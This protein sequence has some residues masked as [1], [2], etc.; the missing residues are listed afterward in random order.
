[1]ILCDD[2]ALVRAGI[3]SVVESFRGW[4]VVAE[5]GDG[6]EALDLVRQHQPD[7][8]LLDLTLPGL[9]G[10]EV[11]QRIRKM[12][13]RTK[14]LILSMHAA[15]EYVARALYAGSTGYLIKEAAVDEL[16]AALETVLLGRRYLS[17]AVDE[18]VVDRVLEAHPSP[19]AE[20]EVLTARQREV[21]QLIAEGHSTRE[22][23]ERLFVSVKTVEAHRM[24]LME[25]LGIRDVPGLVRF[26]IRTGVITPDS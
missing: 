12:D 18:E 25:R 23:A 4:E 16:A 21:L 7:V 6:I 20:L 2:H 14:V 17:R 19:A 9:N 24:Q 1:M 15:P 13:I 10:F 22:I 3:R 8:V 26:A 5:T 11:A